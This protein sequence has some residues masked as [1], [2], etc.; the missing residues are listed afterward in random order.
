M[1]PTT[2]PKYRRLSADE[3]DQIANL[4]AAGLGVRAIGRTLGRPPAT[5]SAELK[6]NTA[7][8]HCDATSGYCSGAA[9]RMAL[10]R[11]ERVHEPLKNEWLRSYVEEKLRLGW[12]PQRIAGRLSVEFPDC[13]ERNL[14]HETIYAWIWSQDA[15]PDLRSLLPRRQLARG[16]RDGRGRQKCKIPGRVGIEERPAEVESREEAG[17]FE[18]DTVIGKQ[19]QAAL[20]TE[21]ERQTRYL[22][23][24]IIP[25]KS[26]PDT[27]DAMLAI[28]GDIPPR[29]R[30]TLTLDNGTEFAQ[31]I[32]LHELITT[33]FARPYHSW[34]RGSNENANGYIRRYFPKGTDFNTVTQA[35]IDHV[36]GLINSMPRKCLNWRTPSE[37]WATL[38]QSHQTTA[39]HAG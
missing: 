21:V 12:T 34:E 1:Q 33:Y 15:P 7:D 23:A 28:F 19:G 3:R 25:S 31:H 29:L 20:H 11:A 8:S 16:K 4:R 14:C 5:I 36:V 2:E 10:A 26:A 13:W 38:N 18:G 24:R 35:E 6:R 37:A 27:L 17:H 22:I 30:K 9:H 39:C 32:A